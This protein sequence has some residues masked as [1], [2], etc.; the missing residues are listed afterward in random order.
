MSTPV[1]LP[2]LGESVT[3]GTVSRWLKQVGDTVE[4]VEA[5]VEVSPD[6][7]DS[8]IPSPVAGVVLAQFVIVD[9]DSGKV[10]KKWEGLTTALVGTGPGIRIAFK[11]IDLVNCDAPMDGLVVML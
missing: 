10:L 9:A 2:A 11:R 8:E 6:K 5:L 1:P 4:A 3:E 7:V